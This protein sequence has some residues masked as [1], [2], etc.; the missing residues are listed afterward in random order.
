MKQIITVSGMTCDNCAT[1]VRTALQDVPGV[2][3]ATVERESG[4]VELDV[5]SEID[6]TALAHAL[7]EDGY[8]LA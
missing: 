4:R 1:H 7:A 2:K 6:R 3:N 5:A 8:A